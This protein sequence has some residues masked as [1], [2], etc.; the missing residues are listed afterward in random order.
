M[1]AK[2]R[3]LRA[4]AADEAS[5]QAEANAAAARAAKLIIEHEIDENELRAMGTSG[6]EEGVHNDG[7]RRTHPTMDLVTGAIGDLTECRPLIRGGG[8]NLWVGAP[9]DVEF[10]LYLSEVI[11]GAAE[12]AW[13]NHLNT[14]GYHSSPHNRKSYLMGFGLGVSKTLNK[15]TAERRAKRPAPT[16]GTSVVVLK[17]QIINSYLDEAYGDINV[18][19]Q[20]KQKDPN[21]IDRKSVV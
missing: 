2:I 14:M 17:D 20:R 11:Q 12:R 5:S 13:K 7:R 19:K 21:F 16:T 3:N 8:A 6:V 4:R 9:S 18:R 10:A 1:I 15:L